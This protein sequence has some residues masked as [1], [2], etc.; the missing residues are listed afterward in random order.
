LLLGAVDMAPIDVAQVYQTL[1]SNGFRSS[2]RSVLAVTSASG[3]PLEYYA[4][5]SEQAVDPATMYL[6]E[7]TLHGV[8]ET[9]TARHEAARFREQLPL[10]GK[11][12]T[13]NDLRDSW[14]AGYGDDLVG[15]VWLGYDDNRESGLTGATGALKVWADVM[16]QL[17]I[18]PRQAL[19]PSDVE[20]DQV[21]REAQ[22]DP[23]RRD[24]YYT[25]ELPF[26]RNRLPDVGWSCEVNDSFFE[27]VMDRFRTD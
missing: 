8:W 15:V 23:A 6:L 1:A 14:F 11:T 17:D 25:Q 2:L 3:A 7:H 4:I 20:F 22:R 26:R 10:A 16:S 18:Q 5:G 24:C 9:G 12:G 21:P 19:A 13:T 27:R